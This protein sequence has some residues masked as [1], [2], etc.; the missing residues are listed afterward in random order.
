M[1]PKSKP[2]KISFREECPALENKVY[3]N[4]GGQG[5]LPKSSLNAITDSWKTIQ[6]L[7]PF[8][9]DVWPYIVS[10]VQK[11][12]EL[13]AEKC[14]VTPHQI[15]LT[16]NVTAGCVLPLW[17]IPFKENDRLLISDSEHPGVV[18]ACQE[19]ARRNNLYIDILPVQTIKGGEE[20]QS[21]KSIVL[22][23][24]KS[25]LTPRTKLVVLSHLLWN[26]GQIM[27]IEEVAK[28]LNFHCS[29]AYLMVDAAQSFGQIPISKAAASADIYAFTGHKWSCGP[30]GLGGVALSERMLLEAKPTLI[31]W[32]SIKNESIVFNTDKDPFHKDGR[33]FELATSCVPL[34]A[35]L[36]CSL[37]LLEREGNATKRLEIIKELSKKLWVDINN[38]ENLETILKEY[39]PAGIVSF[40]HKSNKSSKSI[41]KELGKQDIWIRNLE[42]PDCLRACV[43]IS[44]AFD[45]LNMLIKA[46]K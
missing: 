39:P 11:S 9:N 31:G 41:V 46:L 34:L 14:G 30:E 16:E 22:Q 38:T 25:L 10:E 8:T 42:E 1:S 27:P 37:N 32:R 18:A 21:S 12:K 45:E 19:I 13:L 2:V 29:K 23:R 3:F 20:E 28:E 15:A 43:H 7:G 17:G 5:P 40:T 4:Y 33:K 6:R 36:R 35:G 26:T 44:T 24:I